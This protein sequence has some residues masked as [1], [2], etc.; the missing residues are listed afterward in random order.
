M[1]YMSENV[2]KQN[3]IK[4]EYIKFQS[5]GASMKELGNMRIQVENK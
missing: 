1:Q 4:V 5:F 2:T 3:Y